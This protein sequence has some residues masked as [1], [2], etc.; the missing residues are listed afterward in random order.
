MTSPKPAYFLGLIQNLREKKYPLPAVAATLSELEQWLSDQ[1]NDTEAIEK[2]R[3]DRLL[4]ADDG[5]FRLVVENATI[6]IA[7]IANQVMIYANPKLIDAFSPGIEEAYDNFLFNYASERTMSTISE[8]DKL[9]EQGINSLDPFVGDFTLPGGKKMLMEIH[10]L[11]LKAN[12]RDLKIC[13]MVDVTD[14]LHTRIELDQR[15]HRFESIISGTDAGTWEWNLVENA[16][17]Y[18]KRWAEIAGYELSELKQF[19]NDPWGMIVHPDDAKM[20]NTLTADLLAGKADTLKFEARIRHKKG[21]WIWVLSHGRITDWTD[22]GE[23]MIMSGANLD[24]TDKKLAEEKL[25]LAKEELERSIKAVN[26]ASKVKEDF[27]STMSHEIRTP[28]NV[29]IGLSNLLLRKD[30][31][32]DQLE[33]V[34]V[35]K[36]SGD[37]LLHLVNDI[38]DYSKIQAEK[39]Q[40]ES[41]RFNF[42]E[43]LE[44]IYFTFKQDA[45]DKGIDLQVK[46]D[47]QI[48]DLLEGDVTRLNQILI[49]LLGNALKF[50]RKGK[51][52]LDVS[53]VFLEGRDVTLRF[54]VTDT[55]IGIHPSGLENIFEPFHQSDASITRQFGGTGL[56]LSITKALVNMFHGT[57]EVNSLPERGSSFTVTLKLKEQSSFPDNEW[58]SKWELPFPSK[59]LSILYIED[60]ASNRFLV[61]NLMSQFNIKCI[62]AESGPQ[63]LEKTLEEKYDVILMDIQMPGMDGYQ[64]AKQISVQPKGKNHTTPII[65]FTAEP[66]TDSLKEKLSAH[67]MKDVISKPFDIN[68]FLDTIA[69]ITT[70]NTT[71]G[72]SLDLYDRAAAGEKS[73][74]IYALI[75]EEME[76]FT[77]ALAVSYNESNIQRL[78]A[79]IHK[80]Y[81]I[82]KN[83]R[84]T[85][86]LEKV[87]QLWVMNKIEPA[88]SEIISEIKSRTLPLIEDLR[89]RQ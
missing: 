33:I 86:V 36:N 78:K 10:S 58:M 26:I 85:G 88:M 29:V 66:T 69:R 19:G 53:L 21:H 4:K 16:G 7:V 82:L 23:P 64:T 37:N 9:I 15:I 17:L 22:D 48:P 54:V 71:E 35:L 60:V 72:Y 6:G 47:P 59:Q 24:I 13:L 77:E 42:R 74:R 81:P 8:R 5:I 31:R 67:N 44:H 52:S 40:L 63:A 20:V 30:P 76:L 61:S 12:K 83:L 65:A 34:N 11:P 51:V 87:D 62:L 56:G 50:T 28:L 89:Q 38:L 25:L 1:S 39:L 18:N 3:E 75:A 2:P 32:P 80:L 49:N 57:I 41:V 79:E 45:S 27:L 14:K 84:M 68:H 70:A 43:F 55:G 46:A 73:N